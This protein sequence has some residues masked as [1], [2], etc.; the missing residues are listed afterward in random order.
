VSPTD[1]Q[2]LFNIAKE[3]GLSTKQITDDLKQITQKLNGGEG[4]VGELL[5][6]GKVAQDLRSSIASFKATT[7]QA[8]LASKELN[9]MMHDVNNSN[10][11]I[12]SLLKDS[13]YTKTFETALNDIAKVSAEAKSMS[14]ELHAVTSQIANEDNLI[15][16]LLSDSSAAN[17]LRKGLDQANSA[18]EKLDENMTA[19]R[20]NFLLRRYFKKKKKEGEL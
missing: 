6:D 8:L 18:S 4:I 20:S 16:V 17:D 9:T 12:T 13:S 3:V 7:S 15:H 19:M 14:V 1:T 11:L 10:G 2:E 5:N